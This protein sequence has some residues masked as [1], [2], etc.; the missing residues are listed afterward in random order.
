M[1]AVL[2]DRLKEVLD[3]PTFVTLVTIQPDGSPQ[4]SPVWATYDGDDILIT[5]AVGS[6][7]ER[8]LRRDPRATVVVQPVDEPYSYAEI[9]GEVALSDEGGR[10]LLDA[11]SV[12]YTG[13]AYAEFN[14]T[15]DPDE[16]LVVLRVTP[17]KVVGR[18][19]A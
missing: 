1:A 16:A 7:K 10:E 8:N 5:S 19:G 4:A 14:P 6:R 15:A 9:R 18:L 13:K 3:A 17:S 11:L 2:S 12:K